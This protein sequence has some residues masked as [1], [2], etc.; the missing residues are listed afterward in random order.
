MAL[1][2]LNVFTVCLD[3][4][5]NEM[6]ANVVSRVLRYV[7]SWLATMGVMCLKLIA[8]ND[9]TKYEMISPQMSK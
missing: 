2:Q 1:S 8:G 6:A 3:P 5:G 9:S 4:E 7:S